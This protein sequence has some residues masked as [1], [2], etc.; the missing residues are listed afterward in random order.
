V[1]ARSDYNVHD[2]RSQ[3]KTLS[4]VFAFGAALGL[5]APAALMA[6]QEPIIGVDIT[7]ITVSGEGSLIE[8][9]LVTPGSGYTTAPAVTVAGGGGTGATV[10]AT[11]LNGAVSGLTITNG[12]VGYTSLP[13]ITIAAPSSGPAT[14]LAPV[15]TAGVITSIPIASGGSGY[16]SANP[17]EVFV[18]G[19]GSGARV[20]AV[21]LNGSVTAITI[22]NG[23]IGYDSTTSVS[24]AAPVASAGATAVAADIGKPFPSPFNETYGNVRNKVTIR[25]QAYGTF[26][27]GG[28]TYTF[29][30]NG[31]SIGRSDPV[32][33]GGSMVASWRPPQPG[34]YL[35]TVRVTDGTHTETSLAVR[36]FAVGTAMVGPVDNTLV[37]IGSSVVLQATAT[38]EPSGPNAFLQRIDFYVDTQLVGSDSTYP[39]SFIYTPAATPSTHVVEA[40]G[41]DN[42]GNQISPAGTATR[43]L[44]MVTPIGTPPTVRILNPINGSNVASGS[45]VTFIADAKAPDGFIKNVDFFINGVLLSSSQ[46]FPFTAAW[47][48]KVPGRYQFVAIASDDKSNAVASE[49]IFVTATGSFP[50]ASIT[51]PANGLTVVRGSVV[52][53][54]VAAGGPDGGISSLKT[55]QLLIDGAVSDSLPKMPTG[56]LAVLPPLEEPFTFNWRSNV[57]VGTHRLST[58]V[59][60]V[61]GLTITSADVVIN[62]IANQPPQV[63]LTAPT[64]SSGL[65]NTPVTIT[66]SALDTDG[67]VTGVEFFANGVS[68]GKAT[69]RP[70][71]MAWTPAAVGPV[72]LTAKATDNSDVSTTS[73]EIGFTVDPLT[74]VDTGAGAATNSVY[75][76]DYGAITESGR[77]AFAVNR[78]G[79]GTLV[80]FSTAPAG[81]TYYWTDFAVNPDGTFSVRDNANQVVLSGQSSVTGVSGRFGDKTFIGPITPAS[82]TFTPLVL[83]GVLNAVPNS[84]VTA[85]VGGDGSITLYAAN[86]TNREA[87]SGFLS[88]IGTYA[89]S[90]STAGRFTGTVSNAAGLVSGSVTGGVA[91]SFFLRPVVSRITNISTRALAGS[92]DRTLMAGFVVS[93]SGL[94][95]LLIR[96]VGPTL[97]NFGVQA[98]IAD[99]ILNVI[100][101]TQTLVGSNNDWG[102]STAIA[103]LSEQVGAFPLATSSRDS[104]LQVSIPTGTFTAVVGGG[105]VP[106]PALIEIYDADLGSTVNSRIMNISTRGQVGVNDPLIAGF[107]ITGDQRK[108]LLIRAVGPTLTSFGMTGALS[109]PRIEV[110]FGST[111]IATNNDW[112]E[113]SVLSQVTTTSP[114]VGAFPLNADSK[115]AALVLQLNPGAYTVQVRGAAGTSGTALVEIYDADL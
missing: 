88:S 113:T 102:N 78:N 77:F 49:P 37:P 84:Q 80:A 56:P 2:I 96:A 29:L 41:Y 51:T 75:R 21:V 74:T 62:V 87:G 13:T 43:R 47:T 109:D 92:G 91:G 45:A 30:V 73:A 72:V 65:I 15:L 22:A 19:I 3:M 27:R 99:P 67:S 50:T 71:Q 93:G 104:A 85:I 110:L 42:N 5:M 33:A 36:Y 95:P 26:L 44:N 39:Y 17:P 114:V 6:Q 38:P 9:Q 18:T 115:D 69:A 12:G 20:D 40:R 48:P 53:V 28:Y 32:P 98:P 4:R 83:Q 61:N 34:A 11:I 94:K 107:V 7:G 103:A 55:I 101:S 25:A 97:A 108:R 52:P 58:R 79:R 54:T 60:D 76:G 8:V 1:S 111:V 106:G 63:T 82:A 31:Q 24:I 100:S 46:T 90:P 86:G 14:T 10:A 81:K 64:A 112:T 68:I 35:F 105:G 16:S 59:T 57:S 66:A 23:G 70:F 89:F